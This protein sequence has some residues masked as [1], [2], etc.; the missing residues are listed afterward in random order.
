[1]STEGV[2]NQGPT[3]LDPAGATQGQ[4]AADGV[5]RVQPLVGGTEDMPAGEVAQT[6]WR[7]ALPDDLKQHE[8]LKPFSSVADV[9]KALIEVRSKVPE[10]PEKPDGYEFTLP[11]AEAGTAVGDAEKIEVA[12]LAH[13]LGLTNA[14]AN[15]L[16]VERRDIIRAN[17]RRQVEASKEFREK[18]ER[19]LKVELG[20][21]FDETIAAARK[22][23]ER[24]APE[25]IKEV[26]RATG[27][28]NHPAFVK[29]FAALSRAIGEDVLIEGTAGHAAG[30]QKKNIDPVTGQPMLAFKGM[31]KPM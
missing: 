25:A 26:M 17:A 29:W 21:K 1:M 22:A 30:R 27:I 14:Q 3:I 4:G 12:R 9:A 10:V 8:A 24:L 23:A 7:D 6:A 16:L 11:D 19:E 13:K 18:S 5:E 28:G 2:V 31:P 15:A 20:A